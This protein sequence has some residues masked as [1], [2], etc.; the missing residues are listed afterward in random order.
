MWAVEALNLSSEKVRKL[1]LAAISFYALASALVAKAVRQ[2]NRG[3]IKPLTP[4]P[5]QEKRKL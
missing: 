5:K 3:N 2:K 4:Q 1:V